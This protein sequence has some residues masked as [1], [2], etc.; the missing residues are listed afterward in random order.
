MVGLISFYSISSWG[1]SSLKY[2]I[3]TLLSGKFLPLSLYPGFIKTIINILPF[4]IM[5]F[6]P[7]NY[8]VKSNSVVFLE[9]VVFQ[10]FWILIIYLKNMVL[11]NRMVKRLIIQGG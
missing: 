5:Y 7:L 10:L 9:N 3:I 2:A 1:I 6:L 4:K 11:F 8:I